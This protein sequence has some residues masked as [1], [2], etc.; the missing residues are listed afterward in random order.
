MPRKFQPILVVFA[1]LLG[2]SLLANDAAAQRRKKVRIGKKAATAGR[3]LGRVTGFRGWVMRVAISPDGK[4]V[5]AGSDGEVKLI[6]VKSRGVTGTLKTRPGMI[7]ALAYS[8]D[9][10]LLAVGGYQSLRLWDPLTRKPVKDLDGHTGQV[11]CVAFFPNGKRLVSSCQDES[12]RVWDVA[13]G[14]ELKRIGEFDYPV[15]GVAVSPDGKWIATASGD[16]FRVTRAGLVKLWNAES[17]KEKTWTGKDKDGN[18]QI[19][20]LVEH[21][22]AANSVAFSPDGRTLISTSF[23]EKINVYDLKT[24]RPLGYF[25]GHYRPTNDAVFLSDGEIVVSA[26]GGRAKKRNMVMVWN[27]KTGDEFIEMEGHRAP[28]T[29]VAVTPDERV[30]VSAGKDNAVVFWDYRPIRKKVVKFRSEDPVEAVKPKQRVPN[31]KVGRI[32][33]PSSRE[34]RFV[35]RDDTP[36][37]KTLRVGIIGLDTSHVTAFTR[38]LNDKNVNADIANCRVVAAYPKGSPDIESSTKR[39]PG[40]TKAVKQMGVEIVDSIP[41]LIKRVDCVL[42]ETNDGRPHLEQVLPVLKAGKPVFI[43]KPIAGTLADAVAIFEAAK[44]YKTPVFS[45]SSL[46]YMPGAQ[47]VRQGA[48]GKV[49]EAEAWSPAHLEK[50]HPDLFWYG[51]HGVEALFTMMGTGCESVT[52]TKSTHDMDEVVGVWT[53]GRKGTF[54]GFRKGGKRGYGGSAKGTKG[55]LD[56]GK[57][58]GYRPLVVDIVKFFRTRKPPVSE[59]ETLEIYAFMEAADESKRQ[60][61]KPV[62]LEAVM[63]KAR[64]AAKKRLAKLDR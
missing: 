40:Y 41:E 42:L 62:K 44:K 32:A 1:V 2:I 21:E 25:N 29:S 60:G 56:A 45:S 46:R 47:K 53:G 34:F 24:G 12:V 51:I 10:K 4:T 23:D 11:T 50:T 33:N 22:K 3:V 27:L 57:Y 20:R 63:A 18:P 9:G 14:K 43:D 31:P 15:N 55:E 49:Q 64:Q 7:R 5:A 13:S 26:G 54:Q 58:A 17:G 37:T 6:D 28:V 59:R 38:A 36:A 19:V 35:V 16:E 30:I 48:V 52:R 61:G 8:P 39:V